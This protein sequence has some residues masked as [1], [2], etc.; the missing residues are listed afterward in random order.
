MNAV[1][2]RRVWQT[3][4]PLAHEISTMKRRLFLLAALCCP[5]L[6]QA[7]A[8]DFLKQF[9]DNTQSFRAG[10]SQSVLSRSGRKPQQST[11]KLAFLK[12]GKFRWEVE[13]PYPQLMV[14]DGKKVWIHDP[15]LEQVTVKKMDQA[16]GATPAALLSGSSDTLKNFSLSEGGNSDGLDWVEARPKNQEASFDRVRLGF[17]PD[18]KLQAMEMFDNFGQTT[19]LRFHQAESNPAL[20]LSLF[21]FTPPK[22]ADVIGE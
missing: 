3:G 1:F 10:F 4:L 8:V 18:G 12:P 5:L 7:G 22:G 13:Q 15:E 2:L 19:T 11:G 17:T 14:G 20:P 6:A 21:Q 16:L 9:L